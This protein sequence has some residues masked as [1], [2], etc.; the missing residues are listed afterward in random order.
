MILEL[1]QR[2]DAFEW[3]RATAE[4]SNAVLVAVLPYVSNAVEKLDLPVPRP[5]PWNR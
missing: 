5:S 3:V 1:G 2:F 4:Y